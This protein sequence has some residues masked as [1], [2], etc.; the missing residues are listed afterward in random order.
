MIEN[1]QSTWR[2]IFWNYFWVLCWK[3]EVKFKK[4]ALTYQSSKFPNLLSSEKS[5][6]LRKWKLNFDFVNC[7]L[8]VL[9]AFTLS[10]WTE[11]SI[12]WFNFEL[13]DWIRMGLTEFAYSNFLAF[14]LSHSP[15]KSTFF[16]MNFCYRKRKF[17][18]IFR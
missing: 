9:N 2:K 8:I 14:K 15:C 6:E 5:T 17:Q 4:I 13:F 11:F 12:S 18:L 10:Y 3:P 1:Y 16:R 7:S